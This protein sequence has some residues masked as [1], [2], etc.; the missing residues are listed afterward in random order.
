MSAAQVC[1]CVW[2]M[3]LDNNDSGLPLPPHWQMRAA[4]N[5]RW[6]R[7]TATTRWHAI[8]ARLPATTP[9][10]ANLYPYICSQNPLPLLKP[11]RCTYVLVAQWV[12]QGLR[13]VFFQNTCNF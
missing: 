8:M 6:Q 12:S 1:V 10:L 2:Q 11:S 3:P 9:F 13:H 4:I 7:K 5:A